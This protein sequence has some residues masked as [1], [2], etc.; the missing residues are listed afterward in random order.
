MAVTEAVKEAIWMRGLVAEL[1]YVQKKVIVFCDNQS[2]IHLAKHQV[3]HERS[4]HIDVRMHFVRDIVSS[5]EVEIQKI[6][7]DHNPA[8]VLTKSVPSNKLCHCMELVQVME[9]AKH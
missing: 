2:A 5:G 6:S 9:K 7:T 3:F 1:G 8:D 4:K